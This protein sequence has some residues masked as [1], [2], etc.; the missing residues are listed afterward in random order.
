L[1]AFIF[2]LVTTYVAFWVAI[3]AAVLTMAALDIL[4]VKLGWHSPTF[5]GDPDP[6]K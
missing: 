1:S 5:L 2:W 3:V 4:S 6:P